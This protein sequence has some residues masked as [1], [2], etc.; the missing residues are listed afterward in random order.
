MELSDVLLDQL[1]RYINEDMDIEEVALFEQEIS[2]NIQLQEF[3]NLYNNI[4]DI[5]DESKWLELNISNEELKTEIEKFRDDDTVAFISKVKNYHKTN[6]KKPSSLRKRIIAYTSVAACILLMLFM[7][8]PSTTNFNAIYSEH[9]SWSELPT[10]SLKGGILNEQKIEIERTFKLE[11]F[12]N[13]ILLSDAIIDSSKIIQPNVLIYKGIAQLELNK[14]EQ[15]IET[16]KM[17]SNSDALDAHKAYWYTALIYAKQG[18]KEA[19]IES[20]EKIASNRNYF[21]Y[22]EAI[23]LLKQI[24]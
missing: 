7:F 21:K 3:L 20:L 8:W 19:F 16:F 18:N 5:D 12:N 1:Q 13:V 10:F 17:L 11:E 6:I 4:D 22:K 14:F 15:A 24:K 23:K 2:S 9:S